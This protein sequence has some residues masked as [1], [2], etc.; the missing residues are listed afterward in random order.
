MARRTD[1]ATVDTLTSRISAISR[2]RK[3]SARRYTHRR[4]CA[5]SEE[6]A[7]CSRAIFSW[8]RRSLRIGIGGRAVYDSRFVKIQMFV[9]LQKVERKIV[10]Y[11]ENPS[12]QLILPPAR[13]EVPVEPEE[14][15]LN[16]M[17]RPRSDPYPSTKDN[18]KQVK[19][20]SSYNCVTR[21]SNRRIGCP[22]RPS[23]ELKR[24]GRN[25]PQRPF[26]SWGWKISFPCLHLAETRP[27]ADQNFKFPA[28]LKYRTATEGGLFVTGSQILFWCLKPG[29]LALIHNPPQIPDKESPS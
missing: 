5:E 3:P 27:D 26:Q 12:S 1:S 25:R 8:W 9:T 21:S 19:T 15:L 28:I 22:S 14:C 11:A 7:P 29:P 24:P 4:C 17:P 16:N 13:M 6:M 10:G 2:Y 23:A 20:T 18:G